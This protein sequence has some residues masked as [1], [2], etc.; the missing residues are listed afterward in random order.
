MAGTTATGTGGF[1]YD[2][3][4]SSIALSDATAL[5]LHLTLSDA[6]NIINPG[7]DF[8][9]TD[10]LSFSARA[11]GGDITSLSLPSAFEIADYTN[12]FQTERL[13]VNSL[14]IDGAT[15]DDQNSLNLEI[16]SVV[17]AGT[18]AAYGSSGEQTAELSA[19][20]LTGGTGLFLAIK[21]WTGSQSKA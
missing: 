17:D 3:I 20:L 13:T 15:N 16:S 9:L 11:G 10:L 5:D 14:A 1:S 21:Y 18:I 2:G 6:S 12:A 7:F 4:L 19:M 8:G